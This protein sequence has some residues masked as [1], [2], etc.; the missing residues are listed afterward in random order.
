LPQNREVVQN[1]EAAAVRRGYEVAVFHREIVHR[2][3]REVSLEG[4]P[5]RSPIERHPDAAL[6]TGV[7]QVGAVRILAHHPGE[8]RRRD[9]RVDPAPGDPVVVGPPEVGPEIVE[10]V[11]VARDERRPRLVR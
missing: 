2:H 4:A 8:L 9:S 5:R 11:P 1:P 7:E 6:G 10:L 3:G